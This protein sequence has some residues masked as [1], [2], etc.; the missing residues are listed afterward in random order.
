MI[1]YNVLI[2]KKFYMHLH[3]KLAFYKICESI[4]EEIPVYK[5]ISINR[6]IFLLEILKHSKKT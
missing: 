5:N 3:L 2:K 1:S 4:S 6:T